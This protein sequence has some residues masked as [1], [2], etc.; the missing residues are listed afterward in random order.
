MRPH[1]AGKVDDAAPC[2]PLSLPPGYCA[3]GTLLSAG[4]GVGSAA[5][6]AP[7]AGAT[8]PAGAGAGVRANDVSIVPECRVAAITAQQDA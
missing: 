1:G 6:A 3:S 4:A 5:G 2:R 7:G 8:W